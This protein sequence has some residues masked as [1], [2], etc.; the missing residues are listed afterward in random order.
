MNTY[1]M[2]QNLLDVLK[3]SKSRTKNYK[4]LVQTKYLLIHFP[5]IFNQQMQL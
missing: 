5:H 1:R 4:T 3:P 2:L